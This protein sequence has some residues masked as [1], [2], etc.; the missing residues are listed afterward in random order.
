MTER[1]HSHYFREFPYDNIDVYRIIETFE[2]TC[3]AAQHIL[4]KVIATGKRGHKDLQRD[5]QD[6]V[7]SAQR[8]IEML[9]EDAVVSWSSS[10]KGDWFSASPTELGEAAV[11]AVKPWY[12]DTPGWIWYE[13]KGFEPK[14]TK[15]RYLLGCERDSRTYTDIITNVE[16]FDWELRGD[17]GDIVAYAVKDEK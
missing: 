12:P 13:N 9:E 8:K 17:E 10:L 11:E 3:P 16:G 2:I 14:A 7:D 1:K 6:I 5:W 15:I 4:K